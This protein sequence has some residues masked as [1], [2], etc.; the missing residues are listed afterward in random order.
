MICRAVLRAI[1]YIVYTS[2]IHTNNL[3]YCLNCAAM[4]QLFF[5]FVGH[6]IGAIQRLHESIQ[7]LKVMHVGGD[8]VAERSWHGSP[9][10]E[11]FLMK[12]NHDMR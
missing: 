4:K 8:E 11:K 7:P 5:R 2:P 3:L 9:K 12:R 10:C 6:V 1:K